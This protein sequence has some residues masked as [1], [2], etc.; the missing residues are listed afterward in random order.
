MIGHK[1]LYIKTSRRQQQDKGR[2]GERGGGRERGREESGVE[3]TGRKAESF[4]RVGLCMQIWSE[5][6]SGID[7]WMGF[8]R[9]ACD[10]ERCVTKS[11]DVRSSSSSSSRTYLSRHRWSADHMH[12]VYNYRVIGW[13]GNTDDRGWKIEWEWE[14]EWMRLSVRSKWRLEPILWFDGLMES[15]DDSRV[16]YKHRGENIYSTYSTLAISFTVTSS[17]PLRLSK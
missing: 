17:N 9:K 4:V 8:D 6:R 15:S 12:T 10:E 11:L 14:W 16:Q 13:W 5:W 7:W 3:R 2:Q 1:D